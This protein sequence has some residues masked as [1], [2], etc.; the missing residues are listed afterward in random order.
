MSCALRR[1]HGIKKKVFLLI[2][3][4][5][6]FAAHASSNTIELN[7]SRFN[8]HF[9]AL[10][11]NSIAENTLPYPFK[12]LLTQPLMTKGLENFYQR[13]AIIQVI[14]AI[15]NPQEHTYSRM[16]VMNIDSDIA[17]NKPDMAQKDH[18]QIPIEVALITMNLQQLPPSLIEKV[19]HSN[20][21][22]GRLLLQ[23]KLKTI[24]KSVNFYSLP[25]NHELAQL[26]HCPVN[27]TI[28]ARTN[29]LY[30]TDNHQWIARVWEILPGHAY[31]IDYKKINIY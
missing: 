28:Y 17:R 4:G 29:T 22:F 16:I 18:T 19:M 30:R 15:N 3:G 10:K 26:I 12:C 2:L 31:N 13:T 20:I 21:P 1:L 6:M 23:H 14:T 24:S 8:T 5:L 27:K 25:C 11:F 7:W 9:K